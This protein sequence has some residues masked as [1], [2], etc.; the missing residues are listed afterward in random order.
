MP[1]IDVETLKDCT[2]A[3]LRRLWRQHMG[4]KPAPNAKLLLIRELAW[5]AQH[6]THGGFDAE[7]RSLLRSAIRQARNGAG[8]QANGSN[9]AKRRKQRRPKPK[10]QTGAKLVRTWR[11][12]RHEVTVLEEGKRF[13]YRGETYASL[14]EI[15]KQITGSHWSGPRFF[16]LRRSP[17][18]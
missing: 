2:T 1:D 7:T 16:G 18:Q 14:S 9:R 6:R 11:G 12:H 13:E 8:E 10:L 3:E 17:S 5:H 15:A 4:N